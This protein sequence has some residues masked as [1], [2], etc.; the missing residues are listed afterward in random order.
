MRNLTYKGFNYSY[1]LLHRV[2]QS[3]LMLVGIGFDTIPACLVSFV[4]NDGFKD[5]PP[6]IPPP[7]ASL[8]EVVLDDSAVFYLDRVWSGR[9]V[10]PCTLC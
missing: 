2:F 8:E 6:L 1:Q 3:P 7:C 9:N 10:T 4:C 5:P